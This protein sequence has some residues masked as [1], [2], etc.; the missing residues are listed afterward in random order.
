MTPEQEVLLRQLENTRGLSDQEDAVINTAKNELEHAWAS[1]AAVEKERDEAK[2]WIIVRDKMMTAMANITVSD[3]RT[4]ES[5]RL[6]NAKL[7]RVVEAANAY[8]ASQALIDKAELD[9]SFDEEEY[10]KIL[11]VNVSDWKRFRSELNSVNAALAT[12]KEGKD[13]DAV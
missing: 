13:T 9:D 10:V 5:L 1:L 8:F 7:R 11:Q 4:I 6:E 2:H 12:L 3:K